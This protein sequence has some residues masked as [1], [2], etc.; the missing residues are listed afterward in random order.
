[1]NSAA[2]A[3]SLL[4]GTG[5]EGWCYMAKSSFDYERSQLEA[6][7]RQKEKETNDQR[8]RDAA[9]K[10]DTYKV[11]VVSSIVSAVVAAVLSNIGDIFRF[12][13]GLFHQ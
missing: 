2:M 5:S 13:A 3:R 10:R 11:A 12:L 6:E 4:C 7:A 8:A 9:Q 1:M